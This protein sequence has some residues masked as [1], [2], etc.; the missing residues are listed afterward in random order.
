MNHPHKRTYTQSRFDTQFTSTFPSHSKTRTEDPGGWMREGDTDTQEFK[1]Q[2]PHPQREA[3]TGATEE[4]SP[5]KHRLQA[6]PASARSWKK[7]LPSVCVS[8]ADDRGKGEEA[9]GGGTTGFLEPNPADCRSAAHPHPPA[10]M[11]LRATLTL[12][13]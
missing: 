1:R 4:R 13:Y 11:C 9:G 3:R 2:N 10:P 7:L 8:Q 6:S 5:S 12:R